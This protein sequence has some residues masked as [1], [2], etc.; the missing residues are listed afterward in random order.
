MAEA[1]HCVPSLWFDPMICLYQQSNVFKIRIL[2][3]VPQNTT[4][5]LSILVQVLYL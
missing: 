4:A 5:Y 1:W 2:I 3:V